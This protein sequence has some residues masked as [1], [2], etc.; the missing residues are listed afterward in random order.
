[1][2]QNLDPDDIVRTLCVCL[3][4]GKIIHVPMRLVCVDKYSVRDIKSRWLRVP[5]TSS[6]RRQVSVWWE[7]ADAGGDQGA[8]RTH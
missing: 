2:R 7:A 8:A 1:M 5:T 6:Q 4:D 3:A